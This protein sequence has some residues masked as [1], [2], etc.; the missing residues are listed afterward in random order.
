MIS[1]LLLVDLVRAS[2]Q[3]DV[4]SGD[5]TTSPLI[6]ASQRTRGVALAKGPGIIA[7]VSVAAV[8]FRTMDP[9][10]HIEI[11]KGD[12]SRVDVGER[13]MIVEG[14]AAPM[15]MA[16][17]VALNFLQRMSGIATETA[18]YVGAV[19]GLRVRIVDTRKTTPGLRALEKYAVRM[20]GG[21]NHRFGLYDAVLIKD[22]H[23][24]L[25]R[26]QGIGLSEAVRLIKAKAPH[27]MRVEVEVTCPDQVEDVIG[28]GA[29]AILLDNMGVDDIG[30]AVKIARGRVLLEASGGITLGNVRE[31]AGAGVDLISIGAIT[32]SAPSLDISLEIE[33]IES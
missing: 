2:L 19:R 14:L 18:K 12:G 1:E 17:R 9:S 21:F 30:S 16:E 15:L 22:N 10:C 8:A 5:V 24:A 13:I 7:G 26:A 28:A 4:G 11:Q 32:H 6:P 20:G 23:L 33:R 27:T 29:D 25:L 3:E 31:V